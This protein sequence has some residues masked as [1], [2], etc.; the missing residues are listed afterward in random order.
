VSSLLCDILKA[1]DE[2][3]HPVQSMAADMSKMSCAGGGALSLG[4][5]SGSGASPDGGSASDDSPSSPMATDRRT[6]GGSASTPE[7]QHHAAPRRRQASHLTEAPLSVDESLTLH[8][9]ISR[10]ANLAVLPVSWSEAALSC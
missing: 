10:C 1:H 2:R 9:V 6:S 3:R 8:R 4:S 7:V 5:G